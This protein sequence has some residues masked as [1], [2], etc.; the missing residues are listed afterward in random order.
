MKKIFIAF[1]AMACALSACSDD[2]TADDLSRAAISITPE[3]IPAGLDGTTAQVTVTS[4]GDWRL[5]GVCDWAHPSTVS[6][7]SG[8]VV[9]FTIDPNTSEDSREA[10]F[11]FFTGAA[12]APLKITTEPGHSLI[13][14]SEENMTVEAPGGDIRI[15][16]RT[17]IA[18]LTCSFS[19]GGDKWITV[20]ERTEAFGNTV[21]DFTVAENPDYDDRSSVLTIAGEGQSFEVAITQRQVDALNV[22][23]TPLVFDLAAR[24]I[25]VD[26]STNVDYKV[27]IDGNW[28]TR[29][30]ETRG[31]V[32]NTLKFH[33]AQGTSSRV[34][35]I[36]ISG[37]DFKKIVTVYQ[38]DPNAEPVSIPDEVFRDKLVELGY[39]LKIDGGYVLTDNGLNATSFIYE[40]DYD[41]IMSLEGIEMFP[42][43]ETIDVSYNKLTRI[44]ISKLKKVKD[45]NLNNNGLSEIILG[46]NAVE[47]LSLSSLYHTKPGS[48]YDYVMPTSLVVS[49]TYLKQLNLKYTPSWFQSYDQLATID[50]SECPALET[51]NAKRSLGVLK[52]IYLKEG[53]TIANLTYTAGATIEYK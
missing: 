41:E 4:S 47:S 2:D 6:G 16:M 1:V 10:T 35:T 26:V 38:I 25:A 9:T 12:V 31:L 50:V 36:T 19:D 17:N 3:A 29:L 32:S 11:K 34:G 40:S 20:G 14:I 8:D 15:K 37:A 24:D 33:L 42:N 7:K 21:L 18:E 39:L 13:L 30:P 46:D 5:A 49:G 45:L 27:T 23:E 53:Q 51:L 48:S 43:L 28:I 44:D 52:T 22:D